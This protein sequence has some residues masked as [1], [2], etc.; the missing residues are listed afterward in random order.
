M[1]LAPH[2][3]VYMLWP[4]AASAAAGISLAPMPPLDADDDDDE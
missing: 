2:T 1:E 4:G 3:D